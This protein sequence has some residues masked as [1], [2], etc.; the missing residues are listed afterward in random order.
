MT[1]IVF[2]AGPFTFEW[3]D[4]KARSNRRKHGVS[5]E[6]AATV[7]ADPLAQV[8]DDPDH[9]VH[10]PRF[11]L[12]GLSYARRELIVLHVER[13]ERLRIISARRATAR[14][15]AKLKEGS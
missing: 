12:L 7:F 9:S 15:L 14:E 5:F 11:L 3:D 4:T 2:R 1:T 10:E 8:F 6:E 13:G